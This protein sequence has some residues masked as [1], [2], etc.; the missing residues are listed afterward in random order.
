[1]NKYIEQKNE[2]P[3]AKSFKALKNII[4]QSEDTP[5]EKKQ[6]QKKNK[7]NNRRH[8]K[9]SVERKHERYPKRNHREKN[10]FPKE[11]IKEILQKEGVDMFVVHGGYSYEQSFNHLS[12]EEREVLGVRE[13]E[14]LIPFNFDMDTAGALYMFHYTPLQL[15]QGSQ[16][17]F[18]QPGEQLDL[19]DPQF[20]GKN[21]ISLDVGNNKY[22]VVLKDEPDATFIFNNH[23]QER[24][25]K[26]ERSATGI[27]YDMI[28]EIGGFDMTDEEGH[29][30]VSEAMKNKLSYIAKFI[31][32]VDYLDYDFDIERDKDTWPRT[33]YALAYN[34]PHEITFD[35]LG[36]MSQ[37]KNLDPGTPFKEETLKKHI[38][39]IRD[40]D[41][42]S[43]RNYEYITDRS[44]TLDPEGFSRMLPENKRA[45]TLADISLM[46]KKALE[47]SI[48]TIE[49]LGKQNKENGINPDHHTLG[50]TLV[51]R[52]KTQHSVPM[53]F[54][55]VRGTDYDSYIE[56][57]TSTQKDSKTGKKWTVTNGFMISTQMANKTKE[58]REK[59]YKFANYVKK[60]YPGAIMVRGSMI[61]YKA[62]EGKTINPVKLLSS[63]SLL[64]NKQR[65]NTQ[66]RTPRWSDQF[67]QGEEVIFNDE[68]AT[69]IT[70]NK[71][72]L[73][74]KT[75]NGNEQVSRKLLDTLPELQYILKK[76]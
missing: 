27:A 29:R 60:K 17:Y 23:H 74:I 13:K 68:K 19:D 8:Q 33:M 51:A 56:L 36:N 32:R 52:Y 49:T 53:R 31:D 40:K 15:V 61:M 21:I 30:M 22:G 75:P 63:L 4:P 55:A 66:E 18:V 24:A 14:D 62:P 5:S 59:L 28:D 9:G 64:E 42:Q 73:V 2:K 10:T 76:Q 65:K 6:D 57:H 54:E 7:P 12:E 25:L 47:D 41:N 44:K 35:I 1:M 71:N 43:P 16:T 37:Q 48:V 3:V 45:V 67:T 26:H 38:V 69:L 39:A 11:R 34:L 46:R 70:I 58:D 72:T 50:K 20:K